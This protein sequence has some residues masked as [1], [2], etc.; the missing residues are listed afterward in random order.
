MWKDTSIDD[1]RSGASG[2]GSRSASRRK[3]TSFS[4]D[5]VELLR[6]TFETDPYPGISLRENLSQTTGLPESRIQVWF[7]NRRARTLKCKGAKKGLWHTDSPTRDSHTPPHTVANRGLG[8]G[9]ITLPSQGPPPAY[10]TQIKEELQ[11]AC[12]YGQCPPIYGIHE[13]R[14]H[15]GS[16]YGHQKPRAPGNTSTPAMRSSSWVQPGTQTPPVPPLWCPSP[17]DVRN[18]NV[19]PSQAAPYMHP[20][21]KEQQLYMAPRA[22]TSQS[23]TPDTHDS[24]YWEGNVDNSPALGGHFS[25]LDNS[26]N[27]GA[28]EGC[29]ESGRRGRVQPAPLPELSLEEI[30]GEL[31]E[32]WMGGDA[33]DSLSTE[34]DMPFCL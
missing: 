1:G 8:A 13:E 11:E 27:G 16:I 26:W 21:S 3:R 33:M 20:G 6:A 2:S 28:P 9:S 32:D 18:Y 7:Q 19:T 24:G 14:G 5:H 25:Q 23:S 30:L 34:E 12:F 15:Y 4:K 10:H 29:R 17:L 22:S 31:D